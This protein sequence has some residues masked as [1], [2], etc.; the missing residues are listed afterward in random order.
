MI[1]PI[2]TRC[3]T[4]LPMR[5]WEAPRTL[6]DKLAAEAERAIP[7]GRRHLVQQLYRP[8]SVHQRLRKIGTNAGQL[9]ETLSITEALKRPA[10]QARLLSLE[11]RATVPASGTIPWPAPDQNR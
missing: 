9:T 8:A 1:D 6:S 7:E 5:A 3:I 2:N 4:H 11:N 10:A